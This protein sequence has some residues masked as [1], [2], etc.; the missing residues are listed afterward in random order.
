[1]IDEMI[2]NARL[3]TCTTTHLFFLDNKTPHYSSNNR[4]VFL[5]LKTSNFLNVKQL[6][7]LQK[8]LVENELESLKNLQLEHQNPFPEVVLLI[9]NCNDSLDLKSSEA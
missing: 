9:L 4:S 3:L 1:M 8:V 6:F 7:L 5:F 2:M